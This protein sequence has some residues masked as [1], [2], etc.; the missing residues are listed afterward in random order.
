MDE[1]NR[2]MLFVGMLCLTI[3]LVMKAIAML[4]D[5]S[6]CR[7]CRKAM[8]ATARF[9]RRC[10][11]SRT[12][13]VSPNR[14]VATEEYVDRSFGPNCAIRRFRVTNA[15][16]AAEAEAAV[17]DHGVHEGSCHP[18]SSEWRVPIRGIVVYLMS[19]GDWRV[20]VRYTSTAKYVELQSG[21]MM[22]LEPGDK[23]FRAG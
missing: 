12:P 14:A 22:F 17:I 18:T 1:R 4:R 23:I 7:L 21:V 16:S 3:L 20:E 19:A 10:G 13:W 9:C 11:A 6:Q 5:R 2:V 8:P 15:I